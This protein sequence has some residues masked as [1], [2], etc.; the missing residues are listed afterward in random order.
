MVLQVGA[1]VFDPAA[2]G[3]AAKLT[4]LTQAPADSVFG[5]YDLIASVEV[6]GVPHV[7]AYERASGT[8]RFYAAS[9]T[10][11]FFTQAGTGN[12][13]ADWDAI[14]SFVLA[15]K[16]HLICYQRKNGHFEFRGLAKDLSLSA[17]LEFHRSH[18]PGPTAGF[19]MIRPFVSM[20]GVAFMGYNIETGAVAMY[21]VSATATSP[22]GMLPILALNVWSHAWA[23]NWTRFVFFAMGGANLF[24][25][26]NTGGGGNV[27]ID[28]IMDGLATG[29]VEVSTHMNLAEA[30]DQTLNAAIILDDGSPHFVTCKPDGA[31]VIYRIHPD[32]QGWDKVLEVAGPA[33]PAHL[34]TLRFDARRIVLFC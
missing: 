7:L 1:F 28:R 16:P 6:A 9:L 27:N 3:A 12:L 19:T 29:T 4:P 31:S 30:L 24:L 21:T 11:P 17:P 25:K 18:E 14:E 15:N 34:L 33:N 13:G 5:T 23:K 26:T 8:V 2:A 10:P 20:S 22:P 32:C